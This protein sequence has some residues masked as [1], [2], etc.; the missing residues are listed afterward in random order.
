MG[1]QNDRT[2]AIIASII[3]SLVTIVTGPI[4]MD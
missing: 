4:A 2:I 1:G 3:G